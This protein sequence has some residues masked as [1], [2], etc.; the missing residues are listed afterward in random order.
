MKKTA[1]LLTFLLGFISIQVSGK[2]FEQ[3]TIYSKALQQE[4]T[5]YVGLPTGYNA[6]DTST[7][8]PVIIF[9]HG[10]SVTATEM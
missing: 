9:L 1:I 5:Y 2:W 4:K 10:A 6:S 7:K 8:Y 3:K